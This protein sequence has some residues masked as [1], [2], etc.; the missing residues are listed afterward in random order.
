[1]GLGMML[2]GS[3]WQ[4]AALQFYFRARVKGVWVRGGRNSSISRIA[5]S[6][7]PK[8]TREVAQRLLF[9]TQALSSVALAIRATV[10]IVVFLYIMKLLVLGTR[11]GTRKASKVHAINTKT[12][13]HSISIRLLCFG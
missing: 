11:S 7:V 12:R 13:S 6:L 4:T 1:M 5:L 2:I 10:T 3:S 8:K 9:F